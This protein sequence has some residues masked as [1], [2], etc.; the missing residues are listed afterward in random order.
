MPSFRFQHAVH[1]SMKRAGSA[2]RERVLQGGDHSSIDKSIAQPE[3]PKPP[4]HVLSQDAV[5]SWMYPRLRPT[6]DAALEKETAVLEDEIWCTVHATVSG[7]AS[8]AAVSAD[9]GTGMTVA[10][11]VGHQLYPGLGAEPDCRMVDQKIGEH[12]THVRKNGS[13]VVPEVIFLDSLYHPSSYKEHE[14]Q[15]VPAAVCCCDNPLTV[16]SLVVCPRNDSQAHPRKHASRTQLT[17]AKQILGPI[18]LEGQRTSACTPFLQ[19]LRTPL[20]RTVLRYKLL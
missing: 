14:V 12:V 20:H 5:A 10:G 18:K 9:K 6:H 8:V 2:R 3:E 11:R 19:Q 13:L 4:V 1:V 17:R 16:F 15:Q 7:D